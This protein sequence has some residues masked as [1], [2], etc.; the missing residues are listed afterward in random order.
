MT[1]PIELEDGR[2]ASTI[3]ILTQTI[4]VFLQLEP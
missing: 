4:T 1:I 3:R 2:L